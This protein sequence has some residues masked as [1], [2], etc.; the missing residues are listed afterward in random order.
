MAILGSLI[1]AFII[2]H[3][4]EFWARMHFGELEIYDTAKNAGIKDLYSDVM[5]EF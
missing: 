4:N 2:L 1:L 3:M 5:H